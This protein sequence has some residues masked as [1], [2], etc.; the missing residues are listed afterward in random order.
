[1]KRLIEHFVS[2]EKGFVA[3]ANKCEENITVEMY[4]LSKGWTAF[5]RYSKNGREERVDR[6]YPEEYTEFAERAVLALLKDVHISKTINRNNVL[7]NDSK[8]SV[9]QIKGKNQ[10]LFG[11][12]MDIRLGNFNGVSD[13]QG[14]SKQLRWFHPIVVYGGYRG[15]YENWGL[16]ALAH[17][18]TST[19]NRATGVD[20]Q[21]GHVDY[22]LDVG[23]SLHFLNY[24]NPRGLSSFYFGGGSTLGIYSFSVIKPTSYTDK[25]HLMSGGM[26]LD[27]VL[28]WEFM[29]ANFVQFFLQFELKLPAY[30]IQSQNKWGE[31]DTW[32]P[33]LGYKIGVL[34]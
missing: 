1:L 6:L 8:E 23:M 24:L 20:N 4:P 10:Y 21:E 19:S 14:V 32:M 34:F 15:R 27:G 7:K 13:N 29:R 31:I 16:E 3:V 30:Q 17:L 5:A 2:H 26:D 11:G 25:S 18:G 12:A 33:G 28:G 22:Q 9:Q